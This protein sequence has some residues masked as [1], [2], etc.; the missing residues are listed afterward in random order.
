MSLKEILSPEEIIAEVRKFI[1]ESV[2]KCQR[3]NIQR[4]TKGALTLLKNLPGARDAILE[5]AGKVFFFAVN[6][7]IRHIEVR[8]IF[9]EIK[10]VITHNKNKNYF[11]Q[12]Y[13][14]S[15]IP[16]EV[17]MDVTVPDIH[18][19]LTD[20]VAENPEA[21]APLIASWSLDLMGNLKL[22]HST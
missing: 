12:S 3:T 13:P 20:I 11:L 14:G 19:A 17:T 2:K 18:K 9:V 4:V 10:F 22:T 21:W 15:L 1:P 16:S 5:Y 7:Q 6:R 8:Q